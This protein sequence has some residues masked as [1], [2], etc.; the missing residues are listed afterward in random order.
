MTAIAAGYTSLQS[1]KRGDRTGLGRALV[2]QACERLRAIG[3]E[4]VNLQIRAGNEA[5]I[6][7]YEALDFVVEPRTSMSLVLE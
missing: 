3:C 6:R 4:R 5:V 7:F 2:K 1:A